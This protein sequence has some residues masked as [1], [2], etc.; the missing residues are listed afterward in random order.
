MTPDTSDKIIRDVDLAR[1]GQLSRLRLSDL[2]FEALKAQGFVATERRSERIIFKLKF[3]L[4]GTQHV[5]YI[6]G[7]EQAAAVE[8]ELKLLQRDVRLRRRLSELSRVAAQTIRSAKAR[9]APFLGAKGLY[10]HGRAV[11]RRR[12]SKCL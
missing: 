10:F 1:F 12:Q 9:L 5:R 3:R 8:A 4:N 11:R 7:A 2:D 6:R